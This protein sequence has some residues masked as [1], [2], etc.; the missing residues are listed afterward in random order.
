[1]IFLQVIFP[2]FF[3]IIVGY[4]TGR[5][6]PHLDL[7]TISRLVM[8]IL[9][10]ALIFTS[11]LKTTITPADGGVMFAFTLAMTAGIYL[12]CTLTGRFL[13]FS[14]PDQNGLYLS[15]IF[16]NAG[17]YGIPVA[18]FAF[19]AAGMERE[20]L[21]LVFQNL[22]VST[23]GIY[24]ASSSHLNWRDALKK[25]FQ[26]PPFYAVTLAFLMRGL[27]LELPET[28]FKPLSL[29]GQG[30]VPLFLLALGIKLSQTR[31]T[32]H[33]QYI[34]LASLIRLVASPLLAIGITQLFGFTGLTGKIMVLAYS[35]PTAVTATL[36][37]IEFDASPEKV[38]GVTLVTTL[39][40]I[41]TVTVVLWGWL[42]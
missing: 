25:I 26:L 24:F 12:I 9:S 36:Y 28:L 13:K 22:L 19:G 4:V 7:K 40:S 11:L 18:L 20:I 15:T 32:Q 37:S 16:T 5:I 29:L 31:M 30:T 34:S 3:V 27:G 14:R 10:P 2:V 8:Y 39:A 41:V 21:M 1:M 38:S 35:M 42:L 23:L 33:I 17:N 6:N